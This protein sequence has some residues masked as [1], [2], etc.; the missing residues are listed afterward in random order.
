M[1]KMVDVRGLSCPQPVILV[2]N[3]IDEDVFP[4]EV[5]LDSVTSRENVRRMATRFRCTIEITEKDD[6][7]LMVLTK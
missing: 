5:L 3:A 6:E 7:F 4:I 1:S 2:Q